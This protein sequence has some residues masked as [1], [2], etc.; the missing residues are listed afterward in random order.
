MIWVRLAKDSDLE[1]IKKMISGTKC[2]RF[3]KTDHIMV[4]EIDGEIISTASLKI[5]ENAGLMHSL[6]V[7]EEFRDQ[8]IG[9]MT[10]R[11]IIN[12]ADNKDLETLYFICDNLEFSYFLSK[13]HYVPTKLE[14]IQESFKDYIENDQYAFKLNINEFFDYSCSCS[15]N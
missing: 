10:A 13:M 9:D 8:H 3:D 14:K 7:N 4:G 5:N 2:K 6:F 1:S 15:D 12:L 11:A